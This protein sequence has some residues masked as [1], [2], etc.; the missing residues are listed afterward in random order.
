[1]P[2]GQSNDVEGAVVQAKVTNDISLTVVVLCKDAAAA[3]ATKRKLD[4]GVTQLK[5][6]PGVPPDL[7]GAIDVK[8]SVSGRKV[9]AT[10]D[11]KVAPVIKAVKDVAAPFMGGMG[12][13]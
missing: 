5:S 13:K 2:F 3:A 10:T 11:I 4:E 12:G 9:T 6:G 8:T 1:M 7:R